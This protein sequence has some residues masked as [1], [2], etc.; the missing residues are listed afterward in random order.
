M[1]LAT[2][3]G[4]GCQP[5]SEPGAAMATGVASRAV[6]QGTDAP[7][8]PAAVALVARRARCSGEPPV[9]L[10]SGALIAPDVVLTAAHCLALL[11]QDGGYEVFVGQRLLPAPD[12]QFVRVA[13]ALSHPGYVPETHE[14]DVALLRLARAVDVPPFVLPSRS[15]GGP[16]VGD[17][18]RVL[19]YGDTKD[20]QAPAGLR[21][22]GALTVTRVD[23]RAFHAGPAPSMSCVGDSGGPVLWAQ[24]GPEVLAGITVSGDVAC[25]TEAVNVRVEAVLDD[26]IRPFLAEPP[27]SDTSTLHLDAFCR[28][29]CADA[30]EC[31]SGLACV[32]SAGGPGRCVL[33]ALQDGDFGAHCVEDA[34]CASGICARLDSDGAEACRCFTPCA[35]PPEP[36]EAPDASKAEGCASTSGLLPGLAGWV[37]LATRR[38][39]RASWIG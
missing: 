15:G 34:A 30:R 10:C 22:Q 14:N 39:A 38:R 28:E 12:G 37:I 6:V 29:S 33:S 21:R 1:W 7:G 11:G 13:H 9:L 35:A 16:A 27:P 32:A 26:F 23:A 3:V 17:A 31:P 18:T 36:T 25:R 4:L 2:A 24:S 19:G 20:V 5:V 8:D